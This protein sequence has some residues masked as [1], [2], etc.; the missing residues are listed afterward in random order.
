MFFILKKYLKTNSLVEIASK[1]VENPFKPFKILIQERKLLDLLENIS[2]SDREKI[3]QV[4]EELHGDDDYW[5]RIKNC[6]N[7]LKSKGFEKGAMFDESDLIYSIVRLE[8]PDNVV[9][10]GVANGYSTYTLLKAVDA[11]DNGR[12]VSVDKTVKE[13]SDCAED[14]ESTVIPA[15]KE[16]GWVAPDKFKKRW[17]LIQGNIEDNLS[18]L[19]DK[20][21]EPPKI[22]LYD[23]DRNYLE[24]TFKTLKRDG[25]EIILIVDDYYGGSQRSLVDDFVDNKEEIEIYPYNNIAVLRCT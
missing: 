24:D 10:V 23:A 16:A 9:E 4:L 17:E 6:N 25:E 3:R 11:N 14:W 21:K 18:V 1:V 2:D 8:N 20:V 12:L 22:I 5:R 13:N 15:D 19:S 7:E